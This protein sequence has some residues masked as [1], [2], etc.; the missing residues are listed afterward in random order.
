MIEATIFGLIVLLI[1]TPVS[2]VAFIALVWIPL[3]IMGI[4]L[5]EALLEI[6]PGE[7]LFYGGYF[8][9]CG[10]VVSAVFSRIV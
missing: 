9:G 1:L 7:G 2:M 6:T 5:R 3:W 4:N 8:I 10:L